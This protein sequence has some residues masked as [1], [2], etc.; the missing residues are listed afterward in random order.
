MGGGHGNQ[1]S[2]EEN[3]WGA[4]GRGKR[5]LENTVCLQG[6]SL[7]QLSKRIIMWGRKWKEKKKKADSAQEGA[8]ISFQN[9]VL[10]TV[11]F[12]CKCAVN[13]SHDKK[14]ATAK[15]IKCLNLLCEPD[16]C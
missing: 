5:V 3:G 10:A 6:K 11:P 12:L 7:S 8:L 1:L 13:L 4:R 9:T 16:G 2:R 14:G 15:T